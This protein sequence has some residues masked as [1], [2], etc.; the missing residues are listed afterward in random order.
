MCTLDADKELS[1]MLVSIL[2]MPY[3]VLEHKLF[4]A[5]F[6]TDEGKLFMNS[7]HVMLMNN[8]E[9]FAYESNK[10][11]ALQQSINYFY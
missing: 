8:Y 6:L 2:S 3:Y 10:S 7:L 1:V 11:H 5:N 4:S 9:F